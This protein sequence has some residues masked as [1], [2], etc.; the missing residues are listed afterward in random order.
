MHIYLGV[1]AS[2]WEKTQIALTCKY[3]LLQVVLPRQ[4]CSQGFF[5]GGIGAAHKVLSV[6][7]GGGVCHV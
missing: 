4:L 6:C 7:V 1:C 5:L 3:I 2:A